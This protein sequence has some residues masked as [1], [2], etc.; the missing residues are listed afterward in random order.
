MFGKLYSAVKSSASKFAQEATDT[1]KKAMISSVAKLQ[2][3]QSTCAD[4]IF[5]Y[6]SDSVFKKLSTGIA[7]VPMPQS[8]SDKCQE[9]VTMAHKE[10][11]RSFTSMMV[12]SQEEF[13]ALGSSIDTQSADL[14]VKMTAVDTMLGDSANKVKV[15]EKQ[16]VSSSE[17]CA[18]YSAQM[19]VLG[20][21]VE[22]FLEKVKEQGDIIKT[23][24]TEKS[25]LKMRLTQA[26]SANKSIVDSSAA[27]ERMIEKLQGLEAMTRKERDIASQRSKE[28][29][30]KLV[31]VVDVLEETSASDIKVPVKMAIV[32]ISSGKAKNSEE[33]SAIKD[34]MRLE[35]AKVLPSTP[36]SRKSKA[37]SSSGESATF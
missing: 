2:R 5:G 32:D 34:R 18:F 29:N 16:V 25:E 24:E 6:K 20:D 37:S 7:E 30:S 9:L 21:K 26:L 27:K 36:A 3:F 12:E 22:S 35:L 15:L 28:L 1:I 14:A 17:Q 13:M 23:G 33:L 4:R 11:Q 8:S 10:A 19:G 31:S